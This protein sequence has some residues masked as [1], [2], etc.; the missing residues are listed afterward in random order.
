M[1]EISEVVLT[2]KALQNRQGLFFGRNYPFFLIASP[3]TTGYIF[4][5]TMG[6]RFHLCPQ[7]PVYIHYTENAMQEAEKITQFKK[8]AKNRSLLMQKVN[9]IDRKI[10]ALLSA[11]GNGKAGPTGKQ[12]CPKE[13]SGPDQLCRAMGSKSMT[14]DQIAKKTKLSAGTVKVIS[15]NIPVSSWWD[16]DKGMCMRS[17]G[18]SRL[19][20]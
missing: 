10:S 16:T 14:L 15:T 5:N 18:G 17:P 9:R 6:N 2:Y 19:S 1:I 13:G 3:L 7:K 20:W 8:L 11:K 4:P 12:A